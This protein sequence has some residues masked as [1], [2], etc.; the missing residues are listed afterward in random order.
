[1]TDKHED[2]CGKCGSEIDSSRSVDFTLKDGIRVCWAC[3]VRET[4]R[5]KKDWPN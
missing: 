3:F 1:M 4:P 5:P 2:T